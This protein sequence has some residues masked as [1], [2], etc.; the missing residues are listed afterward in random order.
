MALKPIVDGEPP[1]LGIYTADEIALVNAEVAAGSMNYVTGSS[2]TREEDGAVLFLTG[3]G[4]QG[5]FSE[6]PSLASLSGPNGAT[7]IGTPTGTVQADLDARPTASALAAAGGAAGIGFQQAGTGAV[8]RTTQDK[9]RDFVTADDFGVPTNGTSDSSVAVQAMLDAHPGKTLVL[10]P[11]VYKFLTGLTVGAGTEIHAWGATLDFSASHMTGLTLGDGCAIIGAK[12]ILGAGNSSYNAAGQAVVCSGTSN[13]PAAPTYVNGPKILYCNFEGWGSRGVLMQYCLN[14]MVE[15]NTFSHI[16]YAAV[17]GLSCTGGRSDN[18]SISDVSPGT[19]GNAYGISWTRGPGTLV[20]D[21]VSLSCRANNNVIDGIPVWEGLDAHGGDDITFRGNTISN[22][23]TA[24][25]CTFAPVSGSVGRANK[26]CTIE[27]N[28]ID[29]GST[30]SAIRVIGAMTGAVVDDYAEQ[31][32]VSGNRIL[33]GGIA[34][35]NLGALVIQATKDVVITSNSLAAPLLAG[36]NILSDNLGFN[37]AGNTITDP[38]DNTSSAVACILQLSN[39]NVGYIGGNTF[40]FRNA[41]LGTNVANSSIRFTAAMTGND[42]NVGRN[43]YAGITTGKLTFANQTLAGV[44]VSQAYSESGSAVIAVTS[45]GT[46][47][48]SD[49]TFSKQFPSTPKI[50]MSLA[51]PANGGGKIPT[52]TSTNKTVSGFRIIVRPF[53]L[54]SWSASGNVTVDWE[55]TT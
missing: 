25:S 32:V 13:S 18:N 54:T 24:I 34:N 10:L 36:I 49:I 6:L 30:G 29:A 12:K 8:L 47:A 39:N 35:T 16:G 43:S 33:N 15:F 53:D 42:I 14:P 41:A 4:A 23:K 46:S 50:K 27:G 55:A 3:I 31:C 37:I 45:A 5:A 11:R 21:P 40:A 26:R 2:L 28:T 38:W 9:Q 17:H 52:P 48:L 19:S 20:A 44:N 51:E 1:Y 22:C 7:K